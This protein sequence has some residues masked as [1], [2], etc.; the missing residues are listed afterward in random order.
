MTALQRVIS[1]LNRNKITTS[2][3]SFSQDLDN[4][5]G[6]IKVNLLGES[7]AITRTLGQLGK[8]I[9]VLSIR[10]EKI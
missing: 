4:N 9:E 8:S 1:L 6:I 7:G 5:N 3:L 2:E 10:K